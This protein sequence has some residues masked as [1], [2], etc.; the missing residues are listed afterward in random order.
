MSTPAYRSQWDADGN[1]RVNDCGPTCVA[2]VLDAHGIHVPINVISA[3]T[4]PDGDVGSDLRDLVNALTKRG[5]KA[6]AWTGNGYPPA[7]Y[8]ALVDYSGFERAN[9]QDVQFRGWH[10]LIVLSINDM[11]VIVH[12]PDYWGDRRNEGDH[13]RYTRAEFNAAWRPQGDTRGAIV[14]DDPQPATLTVYADEYARVRMGPSI[15]DVIMGGVKTG[16][17]VSVAGYAGDWAIVQ[18]S[19][20][21]APIVHE[22]MTAPVVAYIFGGLLK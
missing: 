12:D 14:W 13:K 11:T 20:G 21:G 1:Q 18:L 16:E 4:M 2:M 22:D 9:V 17:R 5:I 19:A 7:P 3:E 6:S 15:N 8:I 10:W